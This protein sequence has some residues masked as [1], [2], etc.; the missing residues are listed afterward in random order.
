[1]HKRELSQRGKERDGH[2]PH[3]TRREESSHTSPMHER[4]TPCCQPSHEEGKR[5]NHGATLKEARRRLANFH[6][7]REASHVK[8]MK[9][10]EEENTKKR[11]NVE[12][13]VEGLASISKQ[14]LKRKKVQE[15]QRQCRSVCRRRSLVIEAETK[16][17]RR[18]EECPDCRSACRSICLVNEANLGSLS[19]RRR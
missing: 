4:A 7:K 5:A 8:C 11:A 1:M 14:G 19:T 16:T 12:V 10:R 18:G 2:A 13:S 6:A 17:R 3:E 9:G 15:Q